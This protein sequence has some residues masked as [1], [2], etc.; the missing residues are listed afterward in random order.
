MSGFVVSGSGS[1]SADKTAS[2][3]LASFHF[4]Q[5]FAGHCPSL[6]MEYKSSEEL[7]RQWVTDCSPRLETANQRLPLLE[8]CGGTAQAVLIPSL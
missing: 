4:M 5:F 7:R 1:P 8:K 6:D 3:E 2:E